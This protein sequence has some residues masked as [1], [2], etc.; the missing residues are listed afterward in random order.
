MQTFVPYPD[1]KLTAECLDYRRLGKQRV[2]AMQIINCLEGTGSTHWTR[3]P[4][5]RMW[6]GHTTALK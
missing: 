5:V 4:A 2:E 3:H 1:C 6:V